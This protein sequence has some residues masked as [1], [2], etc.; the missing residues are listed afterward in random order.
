MCFVDYI[1]S[2]IFRHI[3]G[4]PFTDALDALKLLPL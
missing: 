3:V 1:H 2:L 4:M